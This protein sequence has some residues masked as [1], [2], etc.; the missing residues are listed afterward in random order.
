MKTFRI[1]LELDETFTL[2]QLWPD[3]DAPENPTTADVYALIADCGGAHHIIRD[4][5][6]EDHLDVHVSEV[7]S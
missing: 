1:T 7:K 6:L 3:G 5:S 2:E 4:W